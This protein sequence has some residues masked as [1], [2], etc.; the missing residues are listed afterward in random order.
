MKHLRYIIIFLILAIFI[1]AIIV[2]PVMPDQMVSHWGVSG[3]ANG[4]TPKIWGVFLI[5]IISAIFVVLLLSI[6]T[7]DPLKNNVKKFRK[8][9]DMFIITFI[10][11]MF[12]VYALTLIWNL[13]YKFDMVTW[14][15]PAFAGLSYYLGVMMN[16]AEPNWFIGIR[17]PWTLSSPIVWNKTHKLGAKLYKVSAIIILAGIILPAFQ[18]WFI[19]LPLIGGSLLLTIYSYFEFK[20]NI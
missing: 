16:H 10:C 3:E 13:G 9:F 12:Y 20:K 7:I 1:T 8:Y 15:I 19:L 17:T 5:P 11:F 14:L 2:Y 18:I 4:Y 6:P